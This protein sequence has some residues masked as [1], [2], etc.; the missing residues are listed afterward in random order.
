MEIAGDGLHHAETAVVVHGHI[1]EGILADK[2]DKLV[3]PFQRVMIRGV[4][5]IVH[6]GSDK[7]QTEFVGQRLD[8]SPFLS[9][10]GGCHVGLLLE[11]R[12]VE[13][14]QIL[15]AGMRLDI[16]ADIVGAV[17]GIPDHRDEVHP[18]EGDD[19]PLIAFSGGVGPVVIPADAGSQGAHLSVESKLILADTA[20]EALG[21][22]T[23]RGGEQRG[24]QKERICCFS[25]FHFYSIALEKDT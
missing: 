21:Q 2:G 13:A 15:D 1:I 5:R 20:L 24:C 4:G 14:E 12:L 23:G 11:I 6:G 8:I 19:T 9:R 22:R 16:F 3:K 10:L 18:L 25:D 7:L 17:V